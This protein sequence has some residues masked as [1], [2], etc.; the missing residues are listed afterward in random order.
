MDKDL[1][2]EIATETSQLLAELDNAL[3]QCNVMREIVDKYERLH[4]IESIAG[5]SIKTQILREEIE[6]M[7]RELSIKRCQ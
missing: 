2:T 3:G 6:L 1:T 7:E 4:N 5:V